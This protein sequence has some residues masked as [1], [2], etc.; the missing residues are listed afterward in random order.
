MKIGTG[1]GLDG[2]RE[3]NTMET[4]SSES[5]LMLRRELVEAMSK[6]HRG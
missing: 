1:L 6:R 3:S 2:E 4:S 5:L